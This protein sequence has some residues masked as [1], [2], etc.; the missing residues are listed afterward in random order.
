[1]SSRNTP[2][3]AAYRAQIKADHDAWATS[4]EARAYGSHRVTED[5]RPTCSHMWPLGEEVARSAACVAAQFARI[6][7]EEAKK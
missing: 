1:M 3:I 7:A 6:A 2:A 4:W 5:F